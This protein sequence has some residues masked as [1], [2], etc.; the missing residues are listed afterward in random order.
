MKSATMTADEKT[1]FAALRGYKHLAGMFKRGGCIE[2][3]KEAP[4]AL[5]AWER[6]QENRRPKQLKLGECDE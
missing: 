3:Y 6:L 4:A 5:D 1:V 2:S